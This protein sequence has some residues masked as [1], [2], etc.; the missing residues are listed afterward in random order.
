MDYNYISNQL[1]RLLNMKNR[2]EQLLKNLIVEYIKTA[3]PVASSLLVD[4]FDEP[5]SSATIRNEMVTLEK[6]GFIVQPH[7]SAGRIPT[8]KGYRYFVEKFL[9]DKEL[10]IKDKNKIINALQKSRDERE[11]KKNLAKILAELSG[12]AVIIAFEKNDVYYTGLTNLFFKPEFNEKDLIID[13]SKVIDRLDFVI[14]KIFNTIN[15]SDIQIGSLCPFNKH[16]ST[17]LTKLNKKSL[18]ALLGPMRMDYQRN[19]EL[20]NF[21]SN[22]KI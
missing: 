9:I 5:I 4:K 6:N 16:C 14:Y 7:I 18:I 8:E 19:W 10:N 15:K 13:I 11:A 20:I 22:I 21:V 12:E 2:Q 3:Q 1:F 17:V